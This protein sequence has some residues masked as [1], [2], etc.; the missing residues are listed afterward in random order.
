MPR[1]GAGYVYGSSDAKNGD[2]LIYRLDSVQSSDSQ[3]DPETQ[4]AFADFLN[5][6]RFIAEYSELSL[7]IQENSKV[8]RTN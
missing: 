6:Q 5:E 3:M 2:Y 1:S 7:T 4:K 8:V